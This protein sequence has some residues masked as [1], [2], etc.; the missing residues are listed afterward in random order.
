MSFIIHKSLSLFL[1]GVLNICVVV[2][3]YELVIKMIFN[4]FWINGYAT[5]FWVFSSDIVNFEVSNLTGVFVQGDAPE[6]I[7]DRSGESSILEITSCYIRCSFHQLQKL[8]SD[9]DEFPH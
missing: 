9:H 7:Y 8:V 5:I 4:W 2:K 3:I 6:W 1:K